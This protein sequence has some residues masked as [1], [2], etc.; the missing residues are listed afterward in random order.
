[1]ADSDDDESGF[2]DNPLAKLGNL[3][4]MD[5]DDMAMFMRPDATPQERWTAPE[6]PAGAAPE[7]TFDP[8]SAATAQAAST[9]PP[10]ATSEA[11]TKKPKPKKVKWIWG[12]LGKMGQGNKAFKQRVFLVKPDGRLR[13][14]MQPVDPKA[15]LD[16]KT[17]SDPLGTITL[18]GG[19]VFEIDRNCY[20]RVKDS[21]L[22][23]LIPPDSD[24]TFIL[25]A[26]DVKKR[27]LWMGVLEALD[28]TRQDPV[29]AEVAQASSLLEGWME[30]MGE[31]RKMNG[32]KTRYFVIKDQPSVL[33]Y[34][35][36]FKSASG[37][38]PAGEIKLDGQTKLDDTTD[39]ELGKNYCFSLESGK[40]K[41]I[42]SASDP[43]EKKHW[44]ELIG[45]KCASN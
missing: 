27:D 21:F 8:P 9:P 24:R 10:A 5:A 33:Q 15:P 11:T 16:I 19:K 37:G 40:R 36:D 25:E 29:E 35:K 42:I 14:Y 1:M 2:M 45:S 17:L 22:F 31:K 26:A 30:K 43:Y 39:C 20:E 12:Y 38:K 23:G 6:T 3:E 18:K 41:Y 7:Q 44:C 32:W 4:E 13:Y 34:Y 28:C